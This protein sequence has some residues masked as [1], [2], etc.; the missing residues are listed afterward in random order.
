MVPTAAR[1][2]T[3]RVPGNRC[4]HDPR[5]PR[6][7]LQVVGTRGKPFP[8]FIRHTLE[9]WARLY[10]DRRLFPELGPRKRTE[11]LEGMVLMG[12]AMT[13]N[14]DR[15]T[16]RSGRRNPDGSFTGITVRTMALWA[17][18]TTQRAY[19]ALWDLR[20][21]GYIELHQPIDKRP[22]GDRRGLAG[23]RRVTKLLFERLGLDGRMRRERREAWQQ[24]RA[25]QTAQTIAQ[26]RQ[27]RRLFGKNRRAK[28]LAERTTRQLASA[29]A[30][31][32]APAVRSV[33]ELEQQLIAWRAR[34]RQE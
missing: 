34:Q 27:L 6:L 13:R 19:R 18:I 1:Y 24:Q 15:L 3:P 29:A 2:V 25:E 4:N 12:R 23:I 7:D 32:P 10:T 21:A 16:L 11:R 14:L 5:R 17:Q 33:A 30:P 8:W 31:T 28:V 22:N 20:D 26:R 9:R